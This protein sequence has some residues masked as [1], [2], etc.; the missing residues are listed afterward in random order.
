MISKEIVIPAKGHF[1]REESEVLPEYRAYERVQNSS[2]RYTVAK[3]DAGSHDIRLFWHRYECAG[4]F[5]T[6]FPPFLTLEGI[7]NETDLDILAQLAGEAV[8]FDLPLEEF[9]NWALQIPWP[10]LDAHQ[11][12]FVF[13]ELPDRDDSLICPRCGHTARTTTRAFLYRVESNAFQT[14]ITQTLAF[15]DGR[16]AVLPYGNPLGE[17]AL[18]PVKAQVAFDHENRQTAFLLF[19]N[20]GEIIER[21]VL[22]E[23]G[24][25]LNGTAVLAH[26]N[27][28]PLNTALA[29]A[30]GRFYRGRLPFDAR[31]LTL[32]TFIE[33]NRFQGYPKDFY[34]AIPFADDTRKIDDSFQTAAASLRAAQYKDIDAVYR[35]YGLPDK[36]A[37]RNAVFMTPSL[38]FYAEE[39]AALPFRNADIFL[40]ILKSDDIFY[41]LSDL[42]SM[43]GILVYLTAAVNEKGESKT[44]ASI[45]K[46]LSRL[47]AAASIYLLSSQKNR[48][49]ILQKAVKDLAAG[50]HQESMP[51]NIPVIK[52][53]PCV[54]VSR[55]DEYDFHALQNT[56]EYRETAVKLKNCLANYHYGN[57]RVYILRLHGN[58]LAAVEVRGDVIVQALLAENRPIQSD[59][60]LY[61]VLVRWA[62]TNRLKVSLHDDAD[63][64]DG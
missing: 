63:E 17:P 37:I 28:G 57:G 54:P 61:A 29:E 33:L 4:C 13:F 2:R 5:R 38:L 35:Q 46:N 21:S 25:P 40:Q 49:S 48:Q 45:K 47:A 55:V 59:E 27:A 7:L 42:H 44:W 3:R 19:N 12:D 62:E 11:G 50:P 14:V 64:Y 34:N 1:L 30:F 23:Q 10:G 8:D 32:N 43:P 53:I 36:K 56:L 22:D 9:F 60:S 26:I 41:F 39:L 16:A 58:P 15:G 18:L 51:Y 52:K 6:F 31:E 20:R 24:N